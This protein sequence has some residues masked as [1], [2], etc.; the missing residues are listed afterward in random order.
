M[1]PAIAAAAA[2][3]G[4]ARCVRAPGPWRPSKLRFDVE[5]QRAPGGTDVVVD[6]EAHRASGLAPLEARLRERCGRGLPLRPP[7]APRSS[8]ER[9]SRARRSRPC[10]R[11]RA[12]AAAR[13]S[14]SRLLV[15]EPMNTTSTGS[16]RARCPGASP[17]Y[18]NARCAADSR[19]APAGCRSRAPARRC[20][21]TS[22]RRGAPGDLRLQRVDVERRASART[23]ASSSLRSV[24]QCSSARS[25]RCPAARTGGRADTRTSCRRAR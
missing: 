19:D 18:A 2:V 8:R 20:R 5:T 6:G 25:H 7:C 14:D 11:G 16:L 24:R 23:C 1:R 9:R 22:P 21:C 15:H 4:L 12:R 13:R 17:M 3:S 10:G